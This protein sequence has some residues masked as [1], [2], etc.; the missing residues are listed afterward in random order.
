LVL[1][2]AA[3]M[4]LILLT[5]VLGPSYGDASAEG[6]FSLALL[7]FI[8]GNGLAWHGTPDPLGRR[9]LGA[10]IALGSSAWLLHAVEY[11]VYRMEVGSLYFLLGLSPIALYLLA[12]AAFGL[13]LMHLANTRHLLGVFTARRR[14]RAYR[15]FGMI[16]LSAGLEAYVSWLNHAGL[17]GRMTPLMGGIALLFQVL[18]GV[19]A[20]ALYQAVREPAA[21]RAPGADGGDLARQARSETF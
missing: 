13:F 18:L 7:A 2:S 20:L 6:G 11:A 14:S 17:V 12:V 5:S 1:V 4:T 3:V 8:A 16:V 9:L 10:A 19:C 21:S 15:L